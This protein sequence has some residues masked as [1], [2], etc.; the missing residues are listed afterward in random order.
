MTFSVLSSIYFQHFTSTVFIIS[1][2]ITGSTCLCFVS[3]MYRGGIIIDLFSTV[4]FHTALHSSSRFSCINQFAFFTFYSLNVTFFV[5]PVCLP[6]DFVFCKIGWVSLCFIFV[7]T[8][9]LYFLNK[10]LFIFPLPIS[11][12]LLL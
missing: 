1:C 8:L 3:L 7:V 2:Y 6:Y 9:I 11:R 4:L 12:I 5:M 10:Q